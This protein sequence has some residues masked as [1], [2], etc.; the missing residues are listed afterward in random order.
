MFRNILELA[1]GIAV[2]PM[3]SLL[4]FFTVFV[5]VVVWLVRMDRKHVQYMER[6]PLDTSGP[7]PNNG[8]TR[9]DG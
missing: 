2:Y 6:L 4:L 8:G 9:Y 7:E 1:D 3:V 5:L